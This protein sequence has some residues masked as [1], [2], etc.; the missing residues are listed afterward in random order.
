MKKRII[1]AFAAVLLLVFTFAA[2]GCDGAGDV[3]DT[4][5]GPY[6]VV[7]NGTVV[8]LGANAD[9][10]MSKLGEAKS[11]QNTGNCGGLGETTIY[12]YDGFS[13]TVVDYEDGDSVIDKI[14]LIDDRVETSKGIY[15]GS[16]KDDVTE[17]YGKATEEKSGALVYRNDGKET[18]FGIKNGMVDSKSMKVVG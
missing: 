14:N 5:N 15:I 2:V 7:I 6:S 3:N 1:F 11:S 9:A 18:V 16:D 13:I 10:V 17:A 4:E 8:E 12:Y